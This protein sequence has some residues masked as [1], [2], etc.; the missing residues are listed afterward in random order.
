MR[1]L[2]TWLYQVRPLALA[3]A[4]LCLCSCGASLEDQ[5]YGAAKQANTLEAWTV[6]IEKH[7]AGK[8]ASAA[9]EAHDR[10]LIQEA[11]ATSDATV[12]AALVTRCR[13]AKS[14]EHIRRLWD[15]AAYTELTR[16]K[17]LEM[18]R[19]Y[20]ERF[21][22][23]A[24][25]AE[26]SA[27]I[28]SIVWRKCTEADTSDAYRDY[29]EKYLTG[30]HAEEAR[31][32][33]EKLEYNAA[34]QENTLQ[35]WTSFLAAHPNGKHT[36]QAK[37]ALDALLLAQA[38]AAAKDAA[39]LQTLFKQCKT[40]A[41]ADTVFRMWHDASWASAQEEHTGESYRKYLL[42]FPGGDHV[43]AANEAIESIDWLKSREI[44][45]SE[46]YSQ[47]LQ[48]H[49]R[50]KHAKEANEAI[51]E[52]AWR[53]CEA[54]GTREAYAEYLKEHSRG[55]HADKARAALTGIEYADVKEQDSIEAYE[56]FL[57]SHHNHK[58]AGKRL[59]ALRYERAVA[60]GDLDDWKA[61]YDKYRYSSWKDD[62]EDIAQ[63]KKN[64]EAEIERLLYE[65]IIATPSLDLCQ[66]Y[67]KRY[68]D[69]PH[70][71]QVIVRM[72]PFMFDH[73]AK[74][75]AADGYLDYLEKYP[76]GYR[77]KDV[78]LR[79]DALVFG[80]LS[81]KEDFRSFERYLRLCPDAKADL[82]ARMEP[83]MRAW[84]LKVNTIEACDKYL[85]RYAEGQDAGQVREALAP[86][87]FRKAQKEDWYSAYEEYIKK[88]P[89]GANVEEAKERIAWL[90]SQHAAPE[91]DFPKVLRQPGGRWAYDT[92]FREKGGKIGFKVTGS[93]CIYDANGSRW[94]TY[95]GSIG[96]G[97]VTV[98]AGGT[99]K[100]DYWCGNSGSHTFCNGYASFTWTG[101]DAGGHRISLTE[102]VMFQHEGCPG[103]EKD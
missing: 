72:E 87:L 43:Q 99:A 38:K 10:L 55:A 19:S 39:A 28:E 98:K 70:R 61:F 62:G 30:V 89:N 27:G 66:D 57:K 71:Q 36:S 101:E 47:F 3:T 25:R 9:A 69:G 78:K 52:L 41:T 8:H 100:E 79:L 96:R 1:Y 18:H 45:D 65:Q 82:V 76:S 16:K 37:Q 84:A 54:K 53:R 34:G 91:I 86:L 56:S 50:G 81:E 11:G 48:K 63:M 35:K 20:L 5:D 92:V 44:G 29:L 88:C 23:G 90:K 13:T 80:E 58:E 103:P 95:G 75:N 21:P 6:F 14:A 2:A 77:D 7:P 46:A 68:R 26:V 83:W 60:S 67:L 31:S 85:S 97:T 49:P 32:A 33:V 15:E 24:H 17:S 73:V 102:K 93:G 12:F 42:H 74:E 59:R 40:A 64:A 51:E 4:L 94:G 22:N